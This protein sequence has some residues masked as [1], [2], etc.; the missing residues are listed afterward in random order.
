MS[1]DISNNDPPISNTSKVTDI[2]FAIKFVKT[3][4]VSTNF[5]LFL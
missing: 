4:E 5:K 2:Q 1:T 3:L